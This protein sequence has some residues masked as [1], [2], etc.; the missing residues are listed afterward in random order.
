MEGCYLLSCFPLACSGCFLIE[1]KTTSPEMVPH[2]GGLSPL[3]TNWENAPQLD[4]ME[5]FPQKK[6]LSRW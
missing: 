3:T 6:L 4:V 2:T 5:A 1:P